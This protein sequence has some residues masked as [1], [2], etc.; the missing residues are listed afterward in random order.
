MALSYAAPMKTTHGMLFA[1]FVGSAAIA[2]CSTSDSTQAGSD[3]ALAEAAKSGCYPCAMT[4]QCYSDEVCGQFSGD[5]FC[6]RTCTKACSSGTTCTTV[7]TEEGQT[8]QACVPND[9]KCGPSVGPDSGTK[10]DSGAPSKDGGASQD[11]GHGSDGGGAK[12]GGGAADAA[13]PT[14]AG[15]GTDSGA[16]VSGSVG[17]SGGSLSSLRFAVVGDTRPATT[18]DVSGYPTA[19]I[20]QIFTD[21]ASAS[22]AIP[23]GVSTGDY[24]YSTPTSNNA[25]PQLQLYTKA[26][27][28]FAN[29]MFPAMGNHECTGYTDSNCGSG[30]A[31]GITNNY[32][33]FLQQ[34][35][36]PLGQTLPYYSIPVNALDGTWTAKFVFVAANAWTAAQSTW[37][38]AQMAQPTTYTFVV[39]HEAKAASTAPGVKPSQAIM[40]KYPY[41]LA[42]VGHTHSYGK[43]GTKEV[44]IGNGGAP[45]TSSVDYGYGLL[46]QRAD[47]AMQVD[48]IDYKTRQPDLSFRFAVNPDGSAASAD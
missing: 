38:E 14:D 22:P 37:F 24:Q 18:D 13:P 6:V 45:L 21:V 42:I 7:V 29:V 17:P 10:Q 39:R 44:T 48:M 3:Q 32:T 30:N 19:I 41:T 8:V 4:S 46:N 40:A 2:A 25:A 31:D 43:T 27:S 34:L 12:D 11:A 36:E 20:T 23:F 28:N 15:G 5:G 35:L 47:G 9:D 33:A 26:R 1:L 16:P